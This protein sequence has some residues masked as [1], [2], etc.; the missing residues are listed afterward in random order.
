DA[1][2][3]PRRPCASSTATL[4]LRSPW[5]GSS[6][7]APIS[8]MR[9][10]Q[11]SPLTRSHP[12]PLHIISQLP[13]PVIALCRQAQ[14]GTTRH[15]HTPLKSEAP[16]TPTPRGHLGHTRRIPLQ[17]EHGPSPDVSNV[18]DILARR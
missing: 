18:R 2:S 13:H 12:D 1:G 7:S 16:D 17:D 4:I 10:T 15:H 11:A 8:K 6:N 3:R 14:L 9:T 5:G